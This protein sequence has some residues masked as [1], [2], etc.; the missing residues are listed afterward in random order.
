MLWND[1]PDIIQ[2][3]L[4]IVFAIAFSNCGRIKCDIIQTQMQIA[5]YRLHFRLSERTVTAKFKMEMQSPFA[6]VFPISYE[7]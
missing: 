5:H 4:Q 2:K 1:I 6:T 3:E 7:S